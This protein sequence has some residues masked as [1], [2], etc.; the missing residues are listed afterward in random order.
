MRRARSLAFSLYIR[1]TAFL[2]S[3]IA[4]SAAFIMPSTTRRRALLA[5][6]EIRDVDQTPKRRRASTSLPPA[7]V[8]PPPKT[9]GTNRRTSSS[10]NNG[11]SAVSVAGSTNDPS[12]TLLFSLDEL[13]QGTL[14]ARPSKR[15]KSPYVADVYLQDEQREVLVHVP[16]LDMCG[17]CVSGATVL[18]KPARKPN[19][20]DKIGPD[21]VSAKYGTP[22]CEFTAQLVWVDDQVQSTDDAVVATKP[23]YSYTPTWVG[24]HPSLGERIAEEWLRRGLI[25][26]DLPP[27]TS[28]Q[29]QFTM[30]L[31][32]GTTMRPDFMTT[33][34]DGTKCLMEVKTVV[35]TDYA[36][37]D[38]VPS[39][40]KAKQNLMSTGGQ[41]YVRTALFPSGNGKQ[42]GPDGEWVV[43]SRAI[44][45]VQELTRIV[46]Q[47]RTVATSVDDATEH[48]KHEDVK[49]EA[50][51]LFVVVR[52]DAEGFRPNHVACPSFAKYLKE[53]EDNGVRVLAK[54]TYWDEE[55]NCYS[56]KDLF[57]D[58]PV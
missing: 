19:N 50:V 2:S 27:I 51:V 33:H 10:G 44:K 6:T 18:V 1:Q 47:S 24:A 25:L 16:A 26:Q 8:T 39:S 15:N 30:Q 46:Q 54:R 37:L 42:K 40:L 11:S 48:S 13:V 35:D 7:I 23:P 57:I 28:I 9:T 4:F 55:G 22:K 45:H 49:Y 41:P 34:E 20:G 5:A 56:D 52:G 14:T 32:D 29:K 31:H 12:A 17:K 43:S 36:S 58:W 38:D 21:A 53:A 3:D